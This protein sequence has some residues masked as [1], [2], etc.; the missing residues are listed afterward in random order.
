MLHPRTDPDRE[1]ERL[2]AQC[3]RFGV[4]LLS[5]AEVVA[6][7]DDGQYRIVRFANDGE[8]RVHAVLVAPG[9]TYRRLDVPG[10]EGFIGAGVHFSA[11]PATARSTGISRSW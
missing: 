5:A 3:R 10:E 7:E 9:S 6:I 2:T 11:Q 8:V 1:A 4:E